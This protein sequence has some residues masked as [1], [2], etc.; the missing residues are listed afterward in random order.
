MTQKNDL[1]P[2]PAEQQG[3]GRDRRDRPGPEQGIQGGFCL[4]G[5]NHG[6]E[7]L[8][9]Q[10]HGGRVPAE[11]RYHHTDTR[12]GRGTA[13]VHRRQHRFPPVE[14][15]LE[16]RAGQIRISGRHG[17]AQP[18]PSPNIQHPDI[19]VLVSVSKTCQ[20]GFQ[21]KGM[22][23]GG[24]GQEP[25]QLFG[26]KRGIHHLAGIFQLPPAPL[27]HGCRLAVTDPFH[28]GQGL[29]DGSLFL[30][31]IVP[32]SPGTKHC[33]RCRQP[34]RNPAKPPVHWNF[35]PVF[36][37]HGVA[38]PPGTAPGSPCRNDIL[39]DNVFSIYILIIIAA[40]EKPKSAFTQT[41][42]IETDV[43]HCKKNIKKVQRVCLVPD[44]FRFAH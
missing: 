27:G 35:A 19:A 21:Q 16:G 41:A 9:F 40:P 7:G 3:F 28:T 10:Q 43:G 32:E 31:L 11:Y 17:P 15:F 23:T 8:R 2:I 33:Q 26:K 5:K 34:Q 12:A 6:S 14:R 4:P 30:T 24:I 38:P 18:H 22:R 20:P 25:G 37:G 13:P 29:L 36:R 42:V 1:F 44:H 39:F